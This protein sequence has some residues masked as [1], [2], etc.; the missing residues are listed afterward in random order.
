MSFTD[1]THQ[2]S[3]PRLADFSDNGSIGNA[4]VTIDLVSIM[5]FIQSTPGIS[6]TLPNPT[7]TTNIRN[8]RVIN[9]GI[10]NISINSQIVTV[11]STLVFNW[12]PTTLVWDLGTTEIYGASGSSSSWI[13]VTV[14][15][16]DFI[17]VNDTRYYLPAGV[18]SNN[19]NVDM[20]GI[21][22]KVMF[23]VEEDAS[24]YY[25]IPTIST[26]YKQGGSEILDSILGRWVSM[27]EKI[28]TKLIQT[29]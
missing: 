11:N 5:V 19:R 1:T 24:N 20:S 8:F 3:L 9:G 4:N 22:T 26:V 29:L 18:L 6:L 21:T 12:N 14:T 23:I 27:I 25:L 10:V 16:A 2:L 13:D 15:D 28:S 7:I 17:A